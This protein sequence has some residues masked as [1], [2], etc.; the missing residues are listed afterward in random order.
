VSHSHYYDTTIPNMVPRIT[1]LDT[2]GA[3][4]R[5]IYNF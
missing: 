5:S 1:V 3:L 4:W 2:E